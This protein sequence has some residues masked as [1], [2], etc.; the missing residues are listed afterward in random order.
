MAQVYE[1]RIV[2]AEERTRTK[3]HKLRQPSQDSEAD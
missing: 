1:L 3:L 2:D